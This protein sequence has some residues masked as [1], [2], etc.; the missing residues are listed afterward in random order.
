MATL[1]PLPISP[2]TERLSSRP[3]A[4]GLPPLLVFFG[5]RDGGADEMAKLLADLADLLSPPA[6]SDN[7]WTASEYPSRNW[8][9]LVTSEAETV[10]GRWLCLTTAERSILDRLGD[11]PFRGFHLIRDPRAMLVFGWQALCRSPV[12]PRQ[13]PALAGHRARILA[14]DDEDGLILHLDYLTPVF[15]QMRCWDYRHPQILESRCEDLA[16][17]PVRELTG[18]LSFLGVEVEPAASM[19]RLGR[20]LARWAVRPWTTAPRPHAFCSAREIGPLVQRHALDSNLAA[21]DWQ[22]HF[23]PRVHRVFK[24]RFGDLLLQLGYEQADDW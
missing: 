17:D 3:L 12:V 7:R 11:Q 16:A 15:E 23:T 20:R 2:Q 24:D 9:T 4:A 8:E 6:S 19:F 13:D 22:T 21:G 1:A 18:I 14:C 5:H 10:R